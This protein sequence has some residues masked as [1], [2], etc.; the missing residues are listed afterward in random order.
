MQT[1]VAVDASKLM[2][3]DE[4]V[5]LELSNWNG[6]KKG[7]FSLSCVVAFQLEGGEGWLALSIFALREVSMEEV[8]A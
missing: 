7:I 5:A 2:D 4:V 3:Q 8:L 1:A 6:G